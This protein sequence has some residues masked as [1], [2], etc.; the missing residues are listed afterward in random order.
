MLTPARCVGISATVMPSSSS[1]AYEMIGIVGLEGETEQRR[2]GTERDV[3]LVPVQLEAEHFLA[4]ESALADDAAVDHRG[5]IG[6]GFRAGETEAGNVAAISEP[7]QPAILLLLGAE[8]HQEF[9]GAERV[10]H[11]HGDGGGER[12]RRNLAHHFGMRIGREAEP[13]E[14]PRD[15]HAEEFLRLDVVPGFLRQVAPFPIDLPVVEHGAE[16][17]DGTVE[18]GLLL[19]GQCRRRI[20]QAASPSRDCR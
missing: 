3:A 13:A 19:F 17:V 5:G 7:R 15:D 16:L 1:L 14:L 9:A 6:A 2:H 20:G 4:F 10:R 8:A 18:E 12:A 11:H